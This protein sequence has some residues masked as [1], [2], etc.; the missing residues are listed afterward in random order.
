MNSFLQSWRWY[1][2]GNVVSKH[3]QRVIV[4]FMAAS[5][6]TSTKREDREET[7]EAQAEAQ[8]LPASDLAVDK[9][10]GILDRM[11]AAETQRHMKATQTADAEG[12]DEEG[13]IDADALVQTSQINDAMKLTARLWSR[14]VAKP[15]CWR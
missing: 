4:Q 9:V 5:C 13:R 15:G 6:G 12:G 7:G 8:A 10:H 2:R 14:L 1:I 11:S 3:A